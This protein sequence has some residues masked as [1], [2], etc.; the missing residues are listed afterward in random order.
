LINDTLTSVSS[1]SALQS[2]MIVKMSLR[3]HTVKSL[4][5]SLTDYIQIQQ[6]IANAA[7]SLQTLR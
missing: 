4:F 7:P 3:C 2:S 6:T 5:D 1:L